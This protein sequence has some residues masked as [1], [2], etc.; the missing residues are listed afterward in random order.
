[1]VIVVSLVAVAV[2]EDDG[3]GDGGSSYSLYAELTGLL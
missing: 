1:M 3:H 2:V